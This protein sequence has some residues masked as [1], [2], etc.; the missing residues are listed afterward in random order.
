MQRIEIVVLC[1]VV[2]SKPYSQSE[3]PLSMI[4]ATV[5]SWVRENGVW[6]RVDGT[7]PRAGMRTTTV[8]A[9]G[10]P[11]P[12]PDDIPD[13]IWGDPPGPPEAPTGLSG[14]AA[15]RSII[16]K[17]NLS[18]YSAYRIYEVYEGTTANF[19]PDTATFANQIMTVS[20]TVISIPHDTGTGPWYIKVCSVNTRGERSA[21]VVFGPY[22]MTEVYTE[23]MN[24]A[25][26]QAIKDEI[27]TGTNA[28]TVEKIADVKTIIDAD[29]AAIELI[30]GPVGPQGPNGAPGTPGSQGIQGLKGDIGLTGL[31][32]VQG[33]IGDTGSQGIQGIKGDTGLT[34]PIGTTGSQGI[35][36]L[37]GDL[38][39]TGPQGPQGIQGPI[40]NTGSQGLQGI[41]GPLGLT[42]EFDETTV[43][44]AIIDA[45]GVDLNSIGSP[46]ATVHGT[47]AADKIAAGTLGAGVIYAGTVAADKV[48]AG[49]LGADVIYAGTIGADKILAGE[50][51]VGVVYAGTVAADKIAAGELGADVVYAGEVAADKIV[52]GAAAID[53]GLFGTIGADKITGTSADFNQALIGDL[54]AG[55][56]KTGSIA[57]NVAYLGTIGAEKI[58]TTVAK[59]GTAQIANGAITN[60]QVGNVAAD[61][62]VAATA[63]VA[64]GT[65]GTLAANKITTGIISALVEMTSPVIRYGKTVTANV[66]STGAGFFLGV[67]NGV[68]KFLIGDATKFL[69]WDGTNLTV[70]GGTITGGV[71]QTATS[72]PRM[73][74]SGSSATTSGHI[75]IWTDSNNEVLN[76]MIGC[77]DGVSGNL[78][79]IKTPVQNVVGDSMQAEMQLYTDTD[80]WIRTDAVLWYGTRHAQVLVDKFHAEEAIGYFYGME[81]TNGHA[82]GVG[83]TIYGQAAGRGSTANPITGRQN[84]V[85]A[86]AGGTAALNGYTE[87]VPVDFGR[88]FAHIPKVVAVANTTVPFGVMVSVTGISTTGCNVVVW[89]ANSTGRSFEWHAID[90]G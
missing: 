43:I 34:G 30:T 59:I 40:G 32:G 44:Q 11:I 53:I 41:Q 20:Q 90:V 60:L 26:I 8:T 45:G 42:G 80:S 17:W 82:D 84:S 49:T 24:A 68:A 48:V 85:F 29:I 33:P 62:I 12:P 51:G 38:G 52:A 13:T 63:D 19:V 6:V 7:I 25:D 2:E 74:L 50:L 69:S 35:Q 23:E 72:G 55:K 66:I 67:V 61:K 47:L 57:A 31:Q 28:Y 16:L 71:F 70:K 54:D 56:I 86:G 39:L 87:T 27:T 46:G 73:I 22:T 77:P 76:G 58:T 88:T 36:G 89:S 9:D 10:I 5:Y 78:F 83:Q 75:D 37:K 79:K 18:I 81:T 65:F 4:Q 64:L 14:S 3:R 15:F 1:L 21:F